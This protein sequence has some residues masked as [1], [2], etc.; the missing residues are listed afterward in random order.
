M[1]AAV[2]M[3]VAVAGAPR[4]PAGLDAV[5]AAI[6]APGVVAHPDPAVRLAAA[7][8]VVQVLRIYAPQPPYT[9]RTLRA[10]LT[11]VVRPLAALSAPP[12]PSGGDRSTATPAAAAAVEAAVRRLALA[13]ALAAV[14]ALAAAA[15]TGQGVAGELAATLVRGVGAATTPRAAAA[16]AACAAALVEGAADEEEEAEEREGEEEEEEDGSGG[17]RRHSVDPTAG[18]LWAVVAVLTTAVAGGVSQGATARS[19]WATGVLGSCLHRVTVP[20]CGLL[21]AAL[22]GDD[23][24]SFGEADNRD[25][26]SHGGGDGDTAAAA[27]AAI[28]GSLPPRTAAAAVVVLARALPDALVYTLPALEGALQNPTPSSRARWVRL[29]AAVVGA[30]AEPAAAVAAN[31]ALWA[32]A[33]RRLRDVDAGVRAVAVGVLAPLAVAGGGRLGG[34]ED[35]DRDADDGDNDDD[36]DGGGASGGVDGVGRVRRANASAADNGSGRGSGG[37]GGQDGRGTVPGREAWRGEL[38]TAIASRLHDTAEP[39][40]LAVLAAIASWAGRGV[41]GEVLRSVS[42]RVTD[43]QPAVRAA[44]VEVLAAEYTLAVGEGVTT[45]SRAAGRG[46]VRRRAAAGVTAVA[47]ADGASS[48]GVSGGGDGCGCDDDGKGQYSSGGAWLS[49]GLSLAAA[50]RSGVYPALPSRV[51]WIPDALLTAHPALVG[52][53]DATA[54]AAAESLLLSRTGAAADAAATASTTAA[55]GA[56]GGHDGEGVRGGVMTAAGATA[57]TLAVVRA[58]GDLRTAATA[59]FVTAL[60]ARAR[61][62][63]A[64]VALAESRAAAAVA[65]RR[66][67][68]RLLNGGGG[69]QRRGSDGGGE[70]HSDPAVTAAEAAAAAAAAAVDRARDG[71]VAALTPPP[72]AP[73]AAGGV[74]ASRAAAAA[75]AA[76]AAVTTSAVAAL[77]ATPD[78]T[79]LRSLSVAVGRGDGGGIVGG[80]GGGRGAVAAAAAADAVRRVGAATGGGRGA[81]A[82]TAGGGGGGVPGGLA[83]WVRTVLLPRSVGLGG[84]LAAVAVGLAASPLVPAAVDAPTGA[85]A[86]AGSGN[87]GGRGGGGGDGKPV[88]SEAPRAAWWRAAALRVLPVVAAGEPASLSAAAAGLTRLLVADPWASVAA[89]G[90]F[91]VAAH[92]LAAAPGDATSA[93]GGGDPPAVQ[94]ALLPVGAAVDGRA[95]AANVA[96]ANHRDHGDCGGCGGGG[97]DGVDVVDGVDGGSGRLP[98]LPLASSP[99]V[100]YSPIPPST[101]S[102]V[103]RAAARALVA[104]WGDDPSL[105]LWQTATAVVASAITTATETGRLD[106]AVGPAAAAAVM[107]K[108]VPAA[109]ARVEEVVGGGLVLLLG[110]GVDGAVAR[111]RAAAAAAAAAWVPA[112]AATESG[113]GEGWVVEGKKG[114]PAGREEARLRRHDQRAGRRDVAVVA[115]SPPVPSRS[116]RPLPAAGEGRQTRAGLHRAAAAAASTRSAEVASPADGTAGEDGDTT[117]SDSDAYS[118]G[119]WSSAS[120]SGSS[121]AA[122]S[123]RDVHNGSSRRQQPRRR[124]QRTALLP[125]ATATFDA[126]QAAVEAAVATAT[127]RA[128]V[129]GVLYGRLGR[130]DHVG[131]SHDGGD[132]DDIA[133]RGGGVDEEA[134]VGASSVASGD[135]EGGEGREKG[136]DG[137]TDDSV[138][139]AGGGGVSDAESVRPS[140]GVPPR[141]RPRPPSGRPGGGGGSGGAGGGAGGG[142]GLAG[143]KRRRI[144]PPPPRGILSAAD[145]AAIDAL[146]DLLL[147]ALAA[148]GDVF[149]RHPPTA[150]VADADAGTHTDAAGDVAAATVATPPAFTDAACGAVR[151]AAAAGILRL[152]R[153][154]RFHGRLSPAAFLSV[155]V[156]VQDVLPD[157]RAGLVTKIGRGIA[158]KGLPFRWAAALVLG[159][160][161]PDRANGMALRGVFSGL[162]ARRRAVAI[163]ARAA[164]VAAADKR[165]SGNEGRAQTVGGDGGDR[166]DGGRGNGGGDDGGGDGGSTLTTVVTAGASLPPPTPDDRLLRLLPESLLPVIVWTVANHPD[167]P[168]DAAAG[169]IDASRYLHYALERLLGVTDYAAVAEWLLS[170]TAMATDATERHATAMAGVA[171]DDAVGCST[172][173]IRAVARRGMGILGRLRAGRVWELVDLPPLPTLPRDLFVAPSRAVAPRRRHATGRGRGGKGGVLAIDDSTGQVEGG[174]GG[175][176]AALL[177]TVAPPGAAVTPTTA[178]A[179]TSGATA[180]GSPSAAT[181]T[182]AQPRGVPSAALAA[183]VT[184][185]ATATG[186]PAMATGTAAATRWPG[187]DAP[188]PAPPPWMATA[189]SRGPSRR[190]LEALARALERDE[191]RGDLARSRAAD[192]RRAGRVAA[193]AGAVTRAAAAAAATA[194]VVGGPGKESRGGDSGGVGGRGGR[195]SRTR[196]S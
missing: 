89:A 12:P 34:D 125:P 87:G 141:K 180:D 62:R 118:D 136:G 42:G 7:G 69:F 11:A 131:T 61:V 82:V 168:A 44:A 67:P 151:L 20:L 119:C 35:D 33:L 153:T 50:A 1:A 53:G 139:L 155:A 160:V 149:L 150:A 124:R 116:L 165:G 94:A 79:A 51:S 73:P 60:R 48:E 14:R 193:A 152:A 97:G 39:V 65:R 109:Y 142:G 137:V 183:T 188:P 177:P 10:V 162:V 31:P 186:A 157:V 123:R 144:P 13:E 58:V 135:E 80:S 128:L 191:R 98:T 147:G 187:G 115:K 171:A 24:S 178:A 194:T 56:V 126:W 108:G 132:G 85:T 99:I 174:L 196:P 23:D 145:A 49:D 133:S 25:G 143:A 19:D 2:E 63:A 104:H 90:R 72:P 88:D 74:R 26:D 3:A 40:R 83:L 78:A 181:G 27:A 4:P 148:A 22:F 93:A 192:E 172:V 9:P 102:A 106:A 184:T 41:P 29:A 45:A 170:A 21:N 18:D 15:G 36:D 5:A 86:D 156:G 8:A 121:D 81:T 76:A 100:V 37:G 138:P 189:A 112:A 28:G 43:R 55:M 159:A 54:A 154:P 6:A 134:S 113:G 38:V 110:G 47:D 103:A 59:A 130:G 173:R 52:A 96:G 161:D 64:V 166:G 68:P 140:T 163:A 16:L 30:A 129:N 84:D 176:A 185:T 66:A 114:R 105:P 71:L 57:A 75:A 195:T 179:A 164:A 158:A 167:A 46:E 169:Y 117:P 17:A 175:G 70:G 111:A 107:A 120:T 122:S 190:S 92:A 95:P 91:L 127:F 77:A 146:Y 32:A 182:S 101:R